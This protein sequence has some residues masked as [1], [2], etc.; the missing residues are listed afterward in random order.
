M[1]SPVRLKAHALPHGRLVS[2]LAVYHAWTP[3]TYCGDNVTVKLDLDNEFQPDAMLMIEKDRGGQ[4]S[5]DPDDYVDGAPELVAEIAASSVSID[6][7]KK[8]NVY[9][10]NGVREY[11]VWRVRDRAF[12]WFVLRNSQFEALAADSAGIMKSEVFPGLWIDA[13]ALINDNPRRAHEALMEGLK[14]PEHEAFV[15][16][17]SPTA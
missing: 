1:P 6:L 17:L 2:L 15:Q 7:G 13:A 16:R 9:R 4:A 14:S 11:L 12:D 10:R 3:G 5:V 8:L